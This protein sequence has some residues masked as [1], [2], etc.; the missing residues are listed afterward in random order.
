MMVPTLQWTPK[1]LDVLKEKKAPG[2][3]FIIGDK[4]IKGP[5]S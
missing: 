4:Q 3:F 2:I 1:V 5:I